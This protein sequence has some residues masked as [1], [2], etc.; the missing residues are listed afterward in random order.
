MSYVLIIFVL[1]IL[2]LI[3]ELGHLIAA[4]HVKIPIARFSVGFGSKLWGFKKDETEYWLS[5][6]P[7]G[8]YVLPKIESEEEFSQFSTFQ[9]ILFCLGGPLANIIAALLCLS[10]I[11][12]ASSGISLSSVLI[13]PFL[14]ISGMG[15]QIL[16]AIPTLF[17]NPGN[18]SGI[19]GIVAVGGE[20]FGTD[21]IRLLTFSVLLNVNL[22]VFNLLPIP[23]LDGGKIVLYS[24]EKIY[25]PIVRL[26]VPVAITGW[27]LL[28]GLMLYATALDISHL[29]AGAGV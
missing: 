18:L 12:I 10:A 21:I 29:I 26:H 17:D 27:I 7:L 13:A 24:L 19:I 28:I 3:H 9:R 23:P 8:G 15:H 1:G 6:I 2:I 14:E 4:K 20:H 5:L 11:N 25:K 16:A 22:A